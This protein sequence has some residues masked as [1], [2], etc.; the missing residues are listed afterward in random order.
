[1]SFCFI[2]LE[3]SQLSYEFYCKTNVVC[4]LTSSLLYVSLYY[5]LKHTFSP[6]T[7]IGK[8]II[9]NKHLD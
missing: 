8:Y 3:I 9:L 5:Q 6:Y 2:Q 7:V 4:T 1:M